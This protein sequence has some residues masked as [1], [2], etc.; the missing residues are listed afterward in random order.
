MDI[1]YLGGNTVK[2][3]GKNLNVIC[4]PESSNATTKS[5]AKANVV[6]WST[7]G[8]AKI[9]DCM[10]LSIP[11][12]Y[13]VGGSMISGV[14]AR[15]FGD[16]KGEMA[17]IFLFSIDGINVMV[18]GNIAGDVNLSKIEALGKID[19]LIL[20][21]GGN[22]KTMDAA[23]AAALVTKLEPSY[24]IPVGY[25]EKPELFLHELGANPEPIAKL[26]LNPKELP[27]ETQ[28]VLLSSAV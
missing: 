16:E 14:G 2:L 18:T 1:S 26:K 7:D 13:E 25:S 23:H 21:V 20:P 17:T 4:D 6:T 15:K 3:S 8:L 24:V 11:G 19:V 27:P 9:D 10:I 5:I 28:V 22:D 12:E